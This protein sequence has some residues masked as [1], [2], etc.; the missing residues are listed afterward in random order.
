[1]QSNDSFPK[2]FI[3]SKLCTFFFLCLFFNVK[4]FLFLFCFDI[5]SNPHLWN[6]EEKLKTR[7][8]FE[9]QGHR[10]MNNSRTHHHHHHH[11]YCNPKW[12][13]RDTT[14]WFAQLAGG[15]RIHW[16]LFCWGKTSPNRCPGEDTK[17]SDGEVWR[18]RSTLQ[19]KLWPEVVAPDRVLSM[20]KIELNYV[21]MLNW[22][23]WNRTVLAFKLH[24]YTK[25]NCLK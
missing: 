16:L 20:G 13:C 19:I 2:E 3:V 9:F 15:C 24:T 22:I 1:M 4:W 14:P 10:N 21:L 23:A 6:F 25:L 8:N 5:Q 18:M 7:D 12:R 17:Q 11:Q